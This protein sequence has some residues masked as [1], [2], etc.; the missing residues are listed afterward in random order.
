MALHLRAT[1]RHSA[2]NS[3]SRA[4]RSAGHV[5]HTGWGISAGSGGA[6]SLG[7][8]ARP[9]GRGARS[10][11]RGGRSSCRAGAERAARST[12]GRH[13]VLAAAAREVGDPGRWWHAR[14]R[15]GCAELP[16]LALGRSSRHFPEQ[17]PRAGLCE[18]R[19]FTASP[20]EL[21]ELLESSEEPAIPAREP[22]DGP[23]VPGSPLGFKRGPVDGRVV[24]GA[25]GRIFLL[26]T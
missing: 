15:G 18:S 19:L 6:R 11:G 20:R 5:S 13:P 4:A 24:E 17:P 2:S 14:H 9:C 12:W 16:G 21:L 22:P 1:G 23:L 3:S 25:G 8:G 10:C 26:R 7:W